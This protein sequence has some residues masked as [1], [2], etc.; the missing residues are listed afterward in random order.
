MLYFIG[1]G[2]NDAKDITVKGLEAVRSCKYIYLENYTSI[3]ESSKEELEEFYKKEIILADRDL[4]EKQAEEILNRAKKE[5]VAFLVVG[6]IFGAT[7]HTDLMMRAKEKNI[8]T[9]F[10]HNASILT[11]VGIVGLE[12]YKYG[13]TTSIPFNN[14]KVDTPI[15]VFNKN[16]E[17]GL[18]TLF[19][20]DLDPKNNNFLTINDAANYLIK[21]GINKELTAIGCAKVGNENQEIKATTL[22][23][24]TKEKFT[25]Y[26]QCLIIPGNLHFM[27][28]DALELWK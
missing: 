19:L 1:L 10:I 28:E 12:L 17:Q 14:E 27:E 26:P 16:Q 8:K 6:D 24:L 7:T 21:K 23:K 2:L 18:H 22:E 20:L 13:K 9:K 3:L 5:D 15:K 4:V 11:A 25:K